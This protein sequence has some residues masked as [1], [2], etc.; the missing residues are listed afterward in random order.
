MFKTPFTNRRSVYLMVQR[1]RQHPY[2]GL[3]DAA[4]PNASTGVRS[5]NI[6]S[7]QA[8]FFMNSPFVIEQARALAARSGA[9][10]ADASTKRNSSE[11][12]VKKLY[13]LVYQREPTARQLKRSLE[14]VGTETSEAPPEQ[15]AVTSI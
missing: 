10:D 7:L 3:F 14:F 5:S 12:R 2:L 8:L 4:D 1:I 11:E 13:R 9:K 6:T 15:K